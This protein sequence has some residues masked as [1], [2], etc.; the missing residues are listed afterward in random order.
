MSTARTVKAGI[1]LDGRLKV[2]WRAASYS[3]WNAASSVNQRRSVRSPTP[4]RGAAFVI[5]G[6]DRS[7]TI[8]CSR[9]ADV[10]APW[11]ARLGFPDICGHLRSSGPRGCHH[12]SAIRQVRARCA[13][14]LTT[15][16]LHDSHRAVAR[17]RIA[18]ESRRN[19]RRIPKGLRDRPAAPGALETA[20]AK[21]RCGNAGTTAPETRPFRCGISWYLRPGLSEFDQKSSATIS[22]DESHST[23]WPSRT[24]GTVDDERS[25][26]AK[27]QKWPQELVRATGWRFESSLPH[28]STPPRFSPRPRSWPGQVLHRN[29]VEWCPERAKR[30]E[31]QSLDLLL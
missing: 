20:A 2:T 11:P 30:V 6:S 7:A 28:H 5:V 19:G 1:R 18:G 4:Q 26:S 9:T 22:N 15:R 21:G 23:R 3:A 10:L 24:S 14:C 12:R 25:R 31:G 27:S 8:A 13:E 16:C 17:D 29:R